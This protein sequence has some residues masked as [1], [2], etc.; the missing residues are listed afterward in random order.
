M[1]KN[2][3]RV[4]L[5][6]ELGATFKYQQD[7][8]A[9]KDKFRTVK[10]PRQAG[11]T[12]AFAIE[13]LIDAVIN[14]D[15]VICI[16]SPT[17]RQSARMM[18]YIKK[19][20]RKFEKKMGK[21][22]PTEKFTSEEVFFHWGSE[23]YSLPNNPLGIQGIDCNHA[24]IDEAGL[25]G[26]R[27]GEAIMDA[28]V[29]SLSAKEGRLTASGKPR[30][31]QGMLWQFWDPH[32]SRFKEFTHFGITWKDRGAEDPSYAR[33][34]EGHKRILSKLQF[35]ETYE[36]EFVDEGVLIFPH[37]LLEAAQELWK[38]KRYVM[39]PPMGAPQYN[40][41]RYIG[42]DFGRKRNLTEIHVLEKDDKILRTFTMKSLDNMNFEDQKVWIDGLIGRIKP[43]MC[44]VDERGMGLPLLD[45]LQR[46]WGE[47][48]VQPLNLSNGKT[49][50]HAILQCRNAFTDLQ[51]A[52]PDDE[53]LYEQLH[54]YQKEYTDAGNVKYFGKVSE[55]DF[56][57]DKVIA[58]VAAVDAAQSKPF[59]FTIV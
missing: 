50:E 21:I 41:P 1:F 32:S 4:K 55:T 15:Y 46:K 12:T 9:C 23:I 53:G 58:L 11:M 26:Q 40:V 34:V 8:I 6:Y 10:K 38:S 37:T 52:I 17:S 19:A 3:D 30:G 39:S 27:E 20:L 5:A 13:A 36:A 18:R 56:L 25:F 7:I 31:K 47:S 48:V 22:I 33:E 57:D 24:I 51:I 42:V 2:I 16:V 44:K 59:G 35:A 54:S 45:Y 14:T 28:I 29:G 43:I 49:K